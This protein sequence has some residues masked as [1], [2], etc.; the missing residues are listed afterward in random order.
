MIIIGVTGHRDLKE[1][2]LE[3][4]LQQ[5]SKLLFDLKQQYTDMMLYSPLSDGADRLVVQEGIKLNIPFVAILPM[6]KEKYIMDF[7]EISLKEF[8]Q[9][10][11]EAYKITTIPLHKG[12][13]NDSISLYSLQ[14][15]YQYEDCGR[16]VADKCD[17]LIALWDGKY[18][19]LRG[20]TSEVVKYY[21]RT[22]VAKLF[23]IL[24]SRKTKL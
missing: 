23:H 7:D 20:G 24:V 9:L 6:Q 11:Y 22:K 17:S 21:L 4:Y 14:R 16:Y 2:C 8:N 18:I 10:L 15:D 3:D 19:E 1:E 13:T 12:S 5:I